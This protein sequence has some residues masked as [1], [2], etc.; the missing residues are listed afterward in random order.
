MP[1]STKLVRNGAPQNRQ[2]KRGKEASLVVEHCGSSARVIEG[3][4][5][6]MYV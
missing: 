2:V 3:W 4:P 6:G 5:F 1:R